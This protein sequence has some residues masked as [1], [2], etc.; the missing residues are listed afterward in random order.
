MLSSKTID[1]V[2]QK[3]APGVN[4]QI[5]KGILCKIYDGSFII[6]GTKFIAIPKNAV[7]KCDLIRLETKRIVTAR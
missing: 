1:F 5:G 3:Y 2:P 6:T 4:K 7:P